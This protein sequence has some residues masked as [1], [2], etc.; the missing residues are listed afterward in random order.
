MIE[1][2]IIIKMIIIIIR[3]TII[4]IIAITIMIIVVIIIMGKKNSWSHVLAQNLIKNT[5]KAC[6]EVLVTLSWRVL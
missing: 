4:I 2:R 3:I 1:M 6:C 5:F